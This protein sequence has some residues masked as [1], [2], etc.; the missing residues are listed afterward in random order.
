M[1]GRSH[2]NKKL[3]S[4]LFSKL[5]YFKKAVQKV[6]YAKN[7]LVGES[8]KEVKASRNSNEIIIQSEF[9][10][11]DNYQNEWD[12]NEWTKMLNEEKF[13]FQ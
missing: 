3:S 7:A 2:Q 8:K 13:A 10:F 1:A 12:S 5:S 9:I 11:I 6:T 4:R